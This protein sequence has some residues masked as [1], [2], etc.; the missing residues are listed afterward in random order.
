VQTNLIDW[1]EEE[2]VVEEPKDKVAWMEEQLR[3]LSIEESTALGEHMKENQD[4]PSA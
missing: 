4:F 3:L 1:N 2:T